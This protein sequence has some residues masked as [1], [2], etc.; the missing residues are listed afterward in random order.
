[1]P[2]LQV[3]IIKRGT[4]AKR[5]LAANLTQAVVDSIGCSPD[6]VSIIIREME[7]DDYAHG[8][9]LRCDK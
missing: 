1:M 4:E 7:T 3:E 5:K 6:D 9:V 8:G 2:I